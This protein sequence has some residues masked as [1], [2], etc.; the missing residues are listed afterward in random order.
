MCGETVWDFD[1]TILYN[2]L[3]IDFLGNVKIFGEDPNSDLKLFRKYNTLN[4]T[5]DVKDVKHILTGRLKIKHI[6]DARLVMFSGSVHDVDEIIKFKSEALNK[7]GAKYY[8][9]DD[10][11]FCKKLEPHLKIT[12]TI[13]TEELY[14]TPVEKFT[15]FNRS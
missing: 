12:R 11:A 2:F 3:E 9:D 1:G 5:I 8:V 4:T 15:I 13:S 10:T 14:R 6:I 7:M